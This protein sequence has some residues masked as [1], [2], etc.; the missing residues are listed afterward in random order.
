MST[1]TL[2][3]L[4]SDVIL[5]ELS[6]T[7]C[8]D[9]AVL[10][11]NSSEVSIGQVLGEILL[12]SATAAAKSGGNT[13]NGALTMNATTPILP[14]AAAGVYTVRFT[15]ATA[16]T[17]ENPDGD[18]IGTGAVGSTFADDVQFAIAAGGTAFVAG[19][20][21]DITVA[22]TASRKFVPLDFTAEEGAQV[23]AA[24]ALAPRSTSA[25]DQ[26][27]PVLAR[28]AVVN[29]SNLVWPA[30]ATT[31]QKTKAL[32]QLEARGLVFRASL[33]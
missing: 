32:L 1:T 13:G 25:S 10:L 26:V 24:I 9:K 6:A 5:H 2:Q 15:S 8:R 29:P 3:I 16:F 28:A 4:V 33:T 30:G 14:G 31:A 18:V 7:Y 17:V 23:A 20:G 27:V 11:A 22:P 19:D 21:F 12:A